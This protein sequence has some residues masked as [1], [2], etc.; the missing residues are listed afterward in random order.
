[1]RFCGGGGRRSRVKKT[2][3][4]VQHT[5][6]ISFLKKKFPMSKTYPV[7][8]DRLC[9]QAFSRGTQARTRAQKQ[10]PQQ[11]R[12]LAACFHLPKAVVIQ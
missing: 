7:C 9:L 4:I 2:L 3:Q 1:M 11:L 6:L 10:R 8:E 12:H 5:S